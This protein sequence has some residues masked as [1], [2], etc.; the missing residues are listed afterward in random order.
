MGDSRGG[1]RVETS[2]IR[3]KTLLAA[4]GSNFKE[5]PEEMFRYLK[6]KSFNLE[7]SKSLMVCICQDISYKYFQIHVHCN[8]VCVSERARERESCVCSDC[9]LLQF[10]RHV[11]QPACSLMKTRYNSLVCTTLTLTTD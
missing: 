5:L 2:L 11:H 3:K 7:D 8:C 6:K 1:S 4:F 10:Y 9:S